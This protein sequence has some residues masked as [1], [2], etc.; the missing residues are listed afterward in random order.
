MKKITME[1]VIIHS[2][3]NFGSHRVLV[4]ALL[5]VSREIFENFKVGYSATT[6]HIFETVYDKKNVFKVSKDGR[7]IELLYPEMLRECIKERV[8]DDS[9]SNEIAQYIQRIN[10]P[11]K[12]QNIEES[13]FENERA[14]YLRMI[15]IHINW[16]LNMLEKHGS[17]NSF[18]YHLALTSGDLESLTMMKDF[19]RLVDIYCQGDLVPYENIECKSY[20]VRYE[21]DDEEPKYLEL[22]KLV[23]NGIKYIR[24]IK[25]ENAKNV[26][27]YSDVFL[28]RHSEGYKER[29]NKLE[30]LQKQI[31]EAKKHD[32]PYQSIR[33]YLDEIYSAN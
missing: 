28:W 11:S 31:N 22:Q 2:M 5:Y 14:G 7:F 4:S 8:I 29:Q 6:K 20:V 10:D 9:I 12:I 30:K 13:F 19:Y 18:D 1:D 24:A 25:R 3:H 33:A 16:I 21:Y 17:F 15:S 26:V 27:E 23:E 32:V